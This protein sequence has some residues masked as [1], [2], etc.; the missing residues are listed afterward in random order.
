MVFKSPLLLGVSLSLNLLF[1][2]VFSVL[3]IRRGGIPYIVSKLPFHQ[4][5]EQTVKIPRRRNTYQS[6]YHHIRKQMFEQLP[7]SETEI[8]FIGDS[9]TDQGEWAELLGN[10]NIRNRGI[11][12][13]TTDGVL[14][15]LNEI[16]AS[17]PQKLFL[18]IG[19][20]DLWNEQKPASEIA[21]TYRLI[22]EKIQQQTPETQVFIQSLLPMNTIQYPISV[23][24]S[25]IIAVNRHLQNLASEFSY[26][27][28]DL[29]QHFTNDQK[30]L[31]PLYTVDGVHL[32][33]KGYLNWAKIVNPYVKE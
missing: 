4:Q 22:L 24:N 1:I 20:N 29:H 11:S 23:N 13:D 21:Q 26:T 30:Q 16:T 15:R 9:L 19:A 17:Q 10:T 14:N 33:G 27:Y 3:I 31:D 32:S 12:G 2:S 28:I 7:N 8:I 25:D 18:M 6:T 5:I